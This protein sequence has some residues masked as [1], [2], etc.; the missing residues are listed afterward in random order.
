MLILATWVIDQEIKAAK[1]AGI[2]VAEERELELL[3]WLGLIQAPYLV[4]A[5]ITPY[6]QIAKLHAGTKWAVRDTLWTKAVKRTGAFGGKYNTYTL[7]NYYPK[8]GAFAQRGG[9]RFLAT[10]VGARFIP[11]LGWG[12]LAYDLWHVGKWIGEKTSPV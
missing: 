2:S 10:R 3:L 8:I 4:A 12:L 9:W 7:F 6:Y 5:S 11:V 1:W